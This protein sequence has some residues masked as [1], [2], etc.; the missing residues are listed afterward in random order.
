MT[1]LLPY[2]PSLAS[3]TNTRL[4][5]SCR[6]HQQCRVSTDD[7]LLYTF[8]PMDQ[9][10]LQRHKY[11]YC[12]HKDEFVVGI[13]RPWVSNKTKKRTNNAY[14]RVISNLGQLSMDNEGRLP[15]KLIAYMNHYARTLQEKRDIIEWFNHPELRVDDVLEGE[16]DSLVVGEK[17]YAFTRD[18]REKI[19]EWLG[20]MAD[21]IPVGFAQTL[22]WAHPNTG[23]TMVTVMIGGLR[24][25]MNGDFEVFPGDIIQWYWPFEKDCFHSDGRRKPY[26]N[27]W[28]MKEYADR[29]IAVPPNIAPQVTI[30][31]GGMSVRGVELDSSATTREQFHSRAFGNVSDSKTKLVARVKPYFR[32]DDNPRIF[33]AYRVFAVAIAAARPHEM[34][35]IK[36]SKQSV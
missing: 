32:D 26:I 21:Q 10:E 2:Q 25:V 4:D 15:L 29:V 9:E 33:D 27:G 14:P 20:I 17:Y 24:T 8:P 31:Q 1:D 35:D 7:M 23:D 5:T 34:L 30:G 11:R 6:H 3:A 13:G 18:E 16:G 19:P 28:Q 12:I 36:I 22:G